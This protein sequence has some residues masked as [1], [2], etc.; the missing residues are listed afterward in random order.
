VFT[1]PC[2]EENERHTGANGAISDIEGWKSYFTA[3][4]LLEVKIDEINDLMARWQQAIGKISG[5]TA[6]NQPKRN[7]T[8]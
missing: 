6:K 3:T 1:F 7:L 4:A 5:N 2:D 8:G